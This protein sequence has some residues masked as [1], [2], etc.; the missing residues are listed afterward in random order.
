MLSGFVFVCLLLFL[1]SM[2]NMQTFK[3][4]SELGDL[5]YVFGSAGGAVLKLHAKF[6]MDVHFSRNRVPSFSRLSK[7]SVSKTKLSG[8][9]WAETRAVRLV[10]SKLLQVGMLPV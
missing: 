4:S 8:V 10:L 9:D 5:L 3:R 2:Q 7:V 1:F 6:S